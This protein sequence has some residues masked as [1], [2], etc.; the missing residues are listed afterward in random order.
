MVNFSTTSRNN[1]DLRQNTLI[2]VCSD[3]GPEL[4]AGRSGNLKGYKTHLYEGGIRSSLVVWGPGFIN[5]KAKGTRNKESVFS[6]IDL[7]PSL[8]EFTGT[9]ISGKC[10]L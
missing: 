4:G 6:A 5:E 3:N 9:S 2:L 7:T 8:L 10:K 1:E